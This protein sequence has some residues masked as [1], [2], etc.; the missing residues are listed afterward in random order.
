MKKLLPHILFL[1]SFNTSVFSQ[2]IKNKDT[3]TEI[4]AQEEGDL[5]NDKKPD[6][7]ILEMD[8]K[9]DTRPLRVQIFLSQPNIKTSKLI[10]SSTKIIESQYPKNRNGQHNGNP[11]PDFFIED[12]NLQMLTDINDLK[13]RYTFKFQNGNFELIKISRVIW[14]GKNKTSETEIDLV[15][16]IKIEF[17]QELG[18]DKILNKKQKSVKFKLLP[19]IQDLTFSQLETY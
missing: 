19:K 2:S 5:N 8:V 7:V 3:F 12:G 4:V 13:S 16:G 11:I 6:K 14:D 17:D 15:K 9:S 18:S 10:V 1:F